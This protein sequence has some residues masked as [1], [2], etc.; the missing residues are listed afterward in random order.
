MEKGVKCIDI[1]EEFFDNSKEK[2]SK[3]IDWFMKKISWFSLS[4]VDVS[5]ELWASQGYA[6]AALS[7]IK[8]LQ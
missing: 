8:A 4:N 3:S 2:G 1:N 5:G 6:N 7:T